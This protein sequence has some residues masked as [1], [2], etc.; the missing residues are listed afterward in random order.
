V[1]FPFW[2][3]TNAGVGV[4]VI[5]GVGVA[6]AV[7]VEVG[8]IVAVAVAVSVGVLVS[9]G[10]ANNEKPAC[11][12][13]PQAE[14]KIMTSRMAASTFEFFFIDNDCTPDRA[15]INQSGWNSSIKIEKGIELLFMTDSGGF[16]MTGDDGHILR[17][18]QNF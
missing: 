15:I 10:L 4:G 16:T 5:V 2:T 13:L 1:T 17:Q 12:V 3:M 6:V 18:C 11:P 9:V 14:V 7:G 8:V